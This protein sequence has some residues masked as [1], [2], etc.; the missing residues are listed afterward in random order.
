[1]LYKVLDRFTVKTAQG[2]K[3]IQPGQIIKLEESKAQRLL[4]RGKIAAQ[5]LPTYKIILSKVVNDTVLL[6]N[7]DEDAD[8]L[9]QSGIL[10]AVYSPREIAELKKLQPEGVKAYHLTKKVFPKASI[11]IGGDYDA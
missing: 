5:A 3:D 2:E 10:E 6:A 9:R 8:L 11:E 4:D 7:S 1:M